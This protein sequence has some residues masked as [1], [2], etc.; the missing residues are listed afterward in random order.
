MNLKRISPAVVPFLI[1]IK[2][3]EESGSV[4]GSYLTPKINPRIELELVWTTAAVLPLIDIVSFWTYDIA[5]FL[6]VVMLKYL[7]HTKSSEGL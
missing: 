6:L 5:L 3:A 7:D 1:V 2:R 4:A